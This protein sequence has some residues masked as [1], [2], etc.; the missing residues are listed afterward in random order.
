MFYY[1]KIKEDFFKKSLKIVKPRGA[2][3]WLCQFIVKISYFALVHFFQKSTMTCFS[4][5]AFKKLS[6]KKVHFSRMLMTSKYHIYKLEE[7]TNPMQFILW[8]SDKYNWKYK[9]LNRHTFWIF[10]NFQEKRNRDKN[11]SFWKFQKVNMAI[12]KGLYNEYSSQK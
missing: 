4:E 10:F 5:N 7:C 6:A 3:M 1:R 12:I 11:A 2:K 8:R 9:G